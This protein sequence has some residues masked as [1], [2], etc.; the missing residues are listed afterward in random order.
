MSNEMRQDIKGRLKNIRLPASH[1]LMPLFEAVVNAIHAIEDTKRSDGR[2]VVSI[3]RDYELLPA[4]PHGNTVAPV[5]EFVVKDNGNGFNETNYESFRTS[6]STFKATRGGKGV[7][8]FLWLKAFEKAEIRS[9]FQQGE[10]FRLRRFT[11]TPAG[12]QGGEIEETSERN[13]GSEVRLVDF[14]NTYKTATVRSTESIARQILLHCLDY[15]ILESAPQIVVCEDAPEGQSFELQDI[16][17]REIISRGSPISFRV[18]EYEFTIREFYL[19]ARAEI[20]HNVNFCAASRTVVTIPLKGKI[21]HLDGPLF[22]G[23]GQRVIIASYVFGQLLEERVDTERIGFRIYSQDGLLGST[24]EI[25]WDEIVGGVLR[26]LD[27]SLE[28]ITRESKQKVI[29][30]VEKLVSESA[31]KYRPLLR[32]KTDEIARLPLSLSDDKFE[33][34]VNRIY[35]SWTTSVAAEA[36]ER[37]KKRLEIDKS[38]VSVKQGFDDFFQEL[39]DVT[40]SELASYVVHRGMVL[41][42]LEIFL[43]RLSSGGYAREDAVHE[44]IV[45]LR[46]ASDQLREEDHN[47]WVVDERLA[48][49]HYL[50]SDIPFVQQDGPVEVESDERPD[51][52]IYDNRFAFNEGEDLNSIVVVEFKRPE[53]VSY[54]EGEDPIRQ[55]NTYVRR[56]REGTQKDR[57]GRTINVSANARFYCYVIASLTKQLRDELK[58]NLRLRETPDGEGFFDYNSNLN[59]YIE[60]ISYD[61]LLTDARRRNRAFF[62]RLG[63]KDAH[64]NPG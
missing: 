7:G 2:I 26:E 21:P 53:R 27:K 33:N 8:R 12:I 63:L 18:R 24:D 11:F 40:M 30:R 57:R 43:G 17:K 59:S 10:S 16:F 32:Y 23:E 41:S 39:K 58:Y 60:V 29:R 56:I 22:V 25:T 6:D 49:H 14:R 64:L 42:F 31:P 4:D 36:N 13:I 50:A 19:P 48:Y 34:E 51:I 35:H 54:R 1:G 38:L 61:K 45:P 20:D 46:T 62:D 47:L 28:P 5:A 3:R 55:V 9:V 52:L 37:L 15:F 44:L